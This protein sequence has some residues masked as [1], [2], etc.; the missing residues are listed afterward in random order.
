MQ[1]TFQNYWCIHKIFENQVLNHPNA[2]AIIYEDTSLSY[3]E[4]NQKANQLA[5]YLQKLGIGPE[6]CVGVFVER[7][8][9]MVIGIL[10]VLKAGGVYVLLDP[11]YP[12]ERIAFMLEN[13]QSPIIITQEKLEEKLPVHWSQV[14]YL[15]SDWE[16]ITLESKENLNS[17]V[18]SENLAYIIFTSGSTGKPK[19]TEIPHR[20]ILGFMFEVNYLDLNTEQTFLQYSSVSWDAFTLELW[21]ALLHGGRCV[22][23]SEKILAPKDLG[24]IIQ[25]YSVDTLWLTSALFNAIV[26]L[27]PEVLSSVKQLIIGGEALSVPHVHRALQLLPSTKI[28]N[29]YGPSEC[30]VFSCCYPIPK[31]LDK[32]LQSIPVGKP[33]GDRRVYLLD[34]HLNRVPIGVPGEIYV[35]GLGVARGYNQPELTAEKFIPNPFKDEP[36]ARLYRTGDLARY[37]PDGNIEFIGRIDHQVKIRGFRIEL[38]EIESVLI[39]HPGVQQVVVLIREDEPGNKYLVSYILPN[40]ESP[41]TVRDLRRFLK[42]K[43]PEYMIPSAFILLETLPLTPNGK[44]DHQALPVLDTARPE[45]EETFV[46][47]KTHTEKILA[48]IWKQVLGVE[49]VG[50]NDN[51]FELGGDSIRSIQVLS[52]A[53]EK[54]FN[55]SVQQIFHHQTIQ[56]LAQE[57]K[58]TEVITVNVERTQ[59]FSLISQEDRQNLPENVEDAYPL[60]MLQEGMLF[61]SEYSPENAIYHDIFSFHI[62]APF[63]LQSWQKATQQILTRHPILRTAFE[64]TDYSEP[65]QLVYYTVDIPLQFE[66]ISH[67]TQVEQDKVLTAWI[68][69]E[70]LQGF[71]WRQAP[72]LRF[73]LHRRSEE[74]FQLGV[75]FHHAILD[76]W[77]FASL[78]TELYKLYISHLDNN[79]FFVQ[80]PPAIAYRDFVAL[81]RK[82][83]ESEECRD[84]W[85]QKLSDSTISK[86]PRWPFSHQ[87]D[88][89]QQT[90]I[91]EVPLTPE[92]SEGLR[93]L[94]QSTSVPLKSVLLAAH[95]RVMS[96]LS[97]QSDVLTGLITNGRPEDT[98]G[99]KVLGLFLNTIPFRLKLLGGHWMDLVRKTFEAEQELLA[100]RRYPMAK[101]Q[102]D[103][104]R[105]SL[106]ET[107]F[108]FT[109]FH[110]FQS[111]QESNN[112]E[113]L[114]ENGYAITNFTFL[115]DF[116]VDLSSS[117]VKLT[118]IGDG[119]ELCS[120]QMENISNY[121]AKTLAAMALDPSKSYEF[122]QL[123]SEN[124]WH[125]LIVE[126]N[127]T[128]VNYSEDQCIHQ[129]FEA[130]VER[131]PDAVAIVFENEQLTYWELNI[132][133]NQIA[134][135]LQKLG[136]GTEVL[137]GICVERSL[138]MVIGLLAILK[139]GGA[140][141]PLDP[142]YPKERLAY[143]LSDT[144]ITVLL[145][146]HSLVEK[147]PVHPAHIVCLDTCW[148][149]IAQE[150]QTNPINTS[151]DDNLVY[152]IYTSGSTGKPKGVL[153]LHKGA[154]NRFHWMWKTH[155]FTLGEV[156]C[157]KTSLNF[158]DSVW[159]IFGGL[160][161]GIRTVITPD[162]IV[163]NPQEFV[164]TLGKNKVT[165]LVLVPSLLRILLN[166]Y[167]D[168]QKR[169]PKLKLWVTSGEALSLGLLQNFRQTMPEST[170]LNLYGSSEVAADVTCESINPQTQTPLQVTIG[171]PIAN[172]EVYILD[173]Y[174]Q[175]V[176]LGVTYG[177]HTSASKLLREGVVG[178]KKWWK[179]Q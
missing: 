27:F 169:L 42:E 145:T 97:G 16:A 172:T 146:Q 120:Q 80:P 83:I 149:H 100:F 114:G 123:L 175:P 143:M 4:L 28:T 68:E 65:L 176:P 46:P 163:K 85:L 150:S 141:I 110:I 64:L 31:Q 22:L 117:Q 61:H 174:L 96:L 111:L 1:N 69:S 72:L 29:G 54:G 160:L 33:I 14:V 115:A 18:T 121:Y 3:E 167:P 82:A 101:M 20:S 57:I 104:G 24:D 125:Q 40:Q 70:K 116:S 39:Q 87:V 132:R 5:H 173:K 19:G 147:L 138:S 106:F 44:V 155:P 38:K 78:L 23:Y 15:D 66:D 79:N 98:D 107:A 89:N 67:L 170:L 62:R 63:N 76:G 10:G 168:L 77:S 91:K 148:N 92:V 165:R 162:T 108:N 11:A 135:Y 133:A 2:A 178:S 37:L 71:D 26:D 154:V 60:T 90:I 45:L 131:T 158:V 25:K 166:T 81:E 13:I 93:Q 152:V 140:Y 105:Q 86:L 109:H 156:C 171:Y 179:I 130:Q 122:Q 47:P 35:G 95:L 118:L 6:V 32:T 128:Q 30:T 139:A 34:S 99:E 49:R 56:E 88:K 84:Y 164:E 36:G 129:L 12:L 74:T 127:D 142:A 159:E 153:G 50:I 55:F 8:F 48:E 9:E 134:H 161:Q 41:A 103:L 58:S 119:I 113:V 43:L 102:R 59:P 177:V 51:F 124:E 144:Q 136:V 21:T 17:N 94:A 7:S 112:I 151:T 73:R 75:S 52:Q 157:Q 126:W 53:Q 137:V